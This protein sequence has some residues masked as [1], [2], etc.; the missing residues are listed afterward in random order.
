MFPLSKISLPS[1]AQSLQ[2]ALEEGLRR[3]VTPAGDMV[4]VEDKSYPELRAIRVSLDNA[5]VMDRPQLMKPVGPVEPAL[6]VE[7]FVTSGSPLRIQGAAINL[8]C[9]A[10]NVS[11]GQGRDRNGNLLL[12]LQSAVEGSVS[13]NVSLSDLE[14]LLRAGAKAA[15]VEQGVTVE[16][17]RLELRSRGERALDVVVHVR[18]KKLFLSATVR[19]SG[20]AD[21]DEHLTARV[22]GLTCAGEG[23]LGSL[24]CGFL[25]PHLERFNGREFPLMALPLGEVRLRD[26]QVSAGSGLQVSA[27]FGS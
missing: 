16:D 26:V 7:E 15:A 9:R 11:L 2:Q 22:S 13:I 8:D 5:V 14:D 6:Q 20:S 1:D 25:T 4:S 19:I 27:R 10:T 12:L 18:A 17:V 23:T 24:A 21:V 3:V